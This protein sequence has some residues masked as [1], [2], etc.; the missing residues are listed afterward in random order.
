MEEAATLELVAELDFTTLEALLVLLD[1]A[2]L[3]DDVTV[4]DFAALDEVLL[5]FTTVELTCDDGEELDLATLELALDEAVED[6]LTELLALLTG[7]EELAEPVGLLECFVLDFL[8]EDETFP[9][10][11]LPDEATDFVDDAL[12]ELDG[13]V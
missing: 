10:E 9:E 2:A 5:D 13:T 12:V 8:P 6:F 11:I 1:L 3:D 4:L 7:L